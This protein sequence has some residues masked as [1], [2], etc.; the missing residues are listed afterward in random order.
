M[1]K[2]YLTNKA[3]EDLSHIWNYNCETWSKQQADRYYTMLLDFCKELANT[4]EIGKKY[5]EVQLNL[6][7]YKANQHIFFYRV[8]SHKEIDVV[9]ILHGRMDLKNRIHD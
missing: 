9:R 4:P 7:G 6:L 2:Y 8:V 1:A 3:V 5:N